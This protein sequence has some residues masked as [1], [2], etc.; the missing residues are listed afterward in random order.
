MGLNYRAQGQFTP[1]G[2]DR[3]SPALAVWS[4]TAISFLFP[5][6]K[7][8]SVYQPKRDDPGRHRHDNTGCDEFYC[9]H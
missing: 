9:M 4:A 7:D 3:Q 5:V 8:E 2:G 1:T 6:G